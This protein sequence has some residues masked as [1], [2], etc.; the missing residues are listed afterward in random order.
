[1]ELVTEPNLQQQDYADLVAGG[2]R[3][4]RRRR[5]HYG[6]VLVQLDVSKGGFSNRLV[7]VN[8]RT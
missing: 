4:F 1:M 3:C 8:M 7:A 5:G 2:G 6:V